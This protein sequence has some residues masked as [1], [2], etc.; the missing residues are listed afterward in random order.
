MPAKTWGDSQEHLALMGL[1][2]SEQIPLIMNMHPTYLLFSREVTVQ[3]HG[4]SEISK[5]DFLLV[6]AS[7]SLLYSEYLRTEWEA[8]SQVQ[9]ERKAKRHREL[10][11]WLVNTE[12][13]ARDPKAT[14]YFVSDY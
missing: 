8:L 5:S 12:L 14:G 4:R 10:G 9:Q 1:V 7:S 2:G 3:R 11:E 13:D 6:P